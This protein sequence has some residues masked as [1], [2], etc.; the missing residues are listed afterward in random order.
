MKF[1]LVDQFKLI[2]AAATS[3]EVRKYIKGHT[4]FTNKDCKAAVARAIKT[5]AF[6]FQG[7]LGVILMK[8]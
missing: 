5:G 7:G 2:N 6:Y 4:A 1:R 8:E 3:E